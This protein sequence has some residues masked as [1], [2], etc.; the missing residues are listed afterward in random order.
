MAVDAAQREKEAFELLSHQRGEK[1]VHYGE[2]WVT[3][4][5]DIFS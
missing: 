2:R 5:S 4:S 3:L 1:I